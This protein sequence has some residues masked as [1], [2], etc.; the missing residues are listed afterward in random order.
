MRGRTPAALASI[1]ATAA[2][3]TWEAR[4]PLAYDCSEHRASTRPHPRRRRLAENPQ[5]LSSDLFDS[6]QRPE[7]SYSGPLPDM[8]SLPAPQGPI[9]KNR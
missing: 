1:D 5:S 9:N 7:L 3:S 6:L 2:N 4:L 8:A